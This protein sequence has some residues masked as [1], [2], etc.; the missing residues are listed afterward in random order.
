MFGISRLFSSAPLPPLVEAAPVKVAGPQLFANTWPK[1]VDA[2]AFYGN[3]AEAGWLHAN[4]VDV[5]PPWKFDVHAS[6][7]SKILIHRKCAE[8]LER[9]LAYV[10]WNFHERQDSIDA[11]GYSKFSGSYNYRPMR[12]GT[13]LS[14]HAYAC[15]IDFDAAENAFHSTKHKFSLTDALVQAF[16]K[17][18]WV[19]GGRWSQPD[20]M[21][22]QA[23]HVS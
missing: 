4:T 20:A 7:G 17:E 3:P 23:A 16:E 11:Y 18:S 2:Q 22:F 10:W 1:Q 5:V 21:H 12:G 13:H 9:V 8:S 19:W 6:E 14:M 15:A